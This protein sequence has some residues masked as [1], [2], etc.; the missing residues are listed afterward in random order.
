MLKKTH[1][2]NIRLMIMKEP[3]GI[4]DTLLL[5]EKTW[6]TENPQGTLFNRVKHGILIEYLE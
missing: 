4:V 1:L 2:G 5:P 3:G 6:E